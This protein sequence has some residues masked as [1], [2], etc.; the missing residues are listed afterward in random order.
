[1]PKARHMVS[2]VTNGF[3]ALAKVPDDNVG[4]SP[5]DHPSTPMRS[6]FSTRATKRRPLPI[7]T[8]NISKCLKEGGKGVHTWRQTKF[9]AHE[10]RQHHTK[11]P[12]AVGKRGGAHAHVYYS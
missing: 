9:P 3:G 1:M 2:T 12:K 8:Y 4:L 5:G 10:S 7:T 11:F 6:A